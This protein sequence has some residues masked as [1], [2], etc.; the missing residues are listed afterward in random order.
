MTLDK[1]HSWLWPKLIWGATPTKALEVLVACA[2]PCGYVPPYY[3]CTGEYLV[4]H[5]RRRACEKMHALGWVVQHKSGPRGGLIWH[6]T[7]KGRLLLDV[8]DN[9]PDYRTALMLLDLP[10]HILPRKVAYAQVPRHR[11]KRPRTR[12]ARPG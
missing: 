5:P 7:D 10:T 9:H 3:R 8:I 4:P 2:R 12:G 6:A 11:L 1:H